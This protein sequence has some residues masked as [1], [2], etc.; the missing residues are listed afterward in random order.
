M[1]LCQRTL[2]FRMYDLLHVMLCRRRFLSVPK[3][4]FCN[5]Y[6]LVKKYYR[7]LKNYQQQQQQQNSQVVLA[8]VASLTELLEMSPRGGGRA[9]SSDTSFNIFKGLIFST[10]LK[11]WN[12]THEVLLDLGSNILQKHRPRKKWWH[13]SMKGVSIC[14]R[15]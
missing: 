5:N 11:I 14:W 2:T 3:C 13:Q 15:G 9:P 10:F 7:K 6:G 4:R 1:F 12:N 8:D